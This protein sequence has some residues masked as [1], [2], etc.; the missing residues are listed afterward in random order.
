MGLAKNGYYSLKDIKKERCQYNIILGERS[1]GKSY[2]VKEE[3]LRNAWKSGRPSI[4]LIRRYEEDIK[5]DGITEYFDDN[6]MNQGASGDVLK[7]TDGQYDTVEC[8]RGVLYFSNRDP[9]TGRLLHGQPCGKVFALSC[10]ERYKSRQYPYITDVIYEEFVTTKLYL[11]NEPRRL[12]H[13]VSTILRKREGHVWM[14]ANSI[15]RVCPYFYEW[16][17]NGIPQMQ[18]GTIDR[19]RIDDTD[20]AVEMSPSR[21]EKSKMFFGQAA[22]SIQGG[23]WECDEFPKLPDPYDSYD[24]LYE[25]YVKVA[26]FSS[27]RFKLELLIDD[28]ANMVIFVSPYNK[29]ILQSIPTLTDEFSADRFSRRFLDRS[30]PAEQTIAYLY[31]QNKICYASNLCGA[32]FTAAIRNMNG[33]LI[34]R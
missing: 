18:A 16:Q 3:A 10:D 22:K 4:A 27:F 8:F 15:S 11:R 24:L 7:I 5:N 9:E 1:P 23:Q 21:K 29:E 6:N 28:D 25:M 14:V 32:D 30:N 31:Q 2:A 17:L 20:I 13:L 26:A 19:Y 12:Q 34:S 33:G